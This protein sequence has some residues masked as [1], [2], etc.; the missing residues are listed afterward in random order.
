MAAQTAV[1]LN[2]PASLDEPESGTLEFDLRA[3]VP[4]PAASTDRTVRIEWRSGTATTG[5]DFGVCVDGPCPNATSLELSLPAGAT[6]AGGVTLKIRTDDYVEGEENFCLW[7][8]LSTETTP[9]LTSTNCFEGNLPGGWRSV[10]IQDP[11]RTTVRMVLEERRFTY[12]AGAVTVDEG[13]SHYRICT[14]YAVDSVH[15]PTTITFE[16]SP[17]DDGLVSGLVRRESAY[18]RH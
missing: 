8:G 17:A 15:P 2:V 1:T 9:A 7:A 14:E 16:Y 18:G 13:A 5:Y 3:T 10:A 6:A 12:P 4:G 11:D